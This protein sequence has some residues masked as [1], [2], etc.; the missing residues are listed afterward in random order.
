MKPNPFLLVPL[1]LALVA[2]IVLLNRVTSPLSVPVAR[3]PI[4]RT[5]P[6]VAAPAH[7]PS[8]LPEELKR[9]AGTRLTGLLAQARRTTLITLTRARPAAQRDASRL[10]RWAGARAGDAHRGMTVVVAAAQARANT[11][12]L[13]LARLGAR[14]QDGRR[15]GVKA[16]E[17]SWRRARIGLQGR[18]RDGARVIAG[19]IKAAPW[20]R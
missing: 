4:S 19:A 7:R 14:L 11:E 9:A 8:P 5:V 18:L 16:L 2:A 15:R 20:S 13:L 12:K 10:S 17:A 1:C 3:S 6:I